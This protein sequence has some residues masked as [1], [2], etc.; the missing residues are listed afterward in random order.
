M[1]LLLFHLKFKSIL[2][3]KLKKFM[4]KS[5]KLKLLRRLKSTNQPKKWKNKC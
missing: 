2:N 3:N 5:R 4:Q 1:I